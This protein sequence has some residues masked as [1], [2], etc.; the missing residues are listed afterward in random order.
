MTALSLCPTGVREAEGP[1]A[2]S[3]V[4]QGKGQSGWRPHMLLC[5]HQQEGQQLSVLAREFLCAW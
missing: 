4:Q 2:D 1:H 5:T 3:C